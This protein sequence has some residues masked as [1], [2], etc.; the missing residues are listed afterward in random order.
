MTVDH[1]DRNVLNNSIQNLDYATE[2]Q[3]DWNKDGNEEIHYRVALEWDQW[4]RQGKPMP[5][6]LPAPDHYF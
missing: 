2:F 1:W 4:V 3:Q 5:V 6:P